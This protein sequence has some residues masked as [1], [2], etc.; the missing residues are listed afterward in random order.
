MAFLFWQIQ[1][2]SSPHLS[3]PTRPSKLPR[4]LQR[5]VPFWNASSNSYAAPE[6][7]REAIFHLHRCFNLLND[8]MCNIGY[9]LRKKAGPPTVHAITL[10]SIKSVI[11]TDEMLQIQLHFENK[12][13]YFL[14]STPRLAEIWLCG[15]CCLIRGQQESHPVTNASACAISIMLTMT[16]GKVSRYLHESTLASLSYWVQ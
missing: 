6:F 8:D 4:L 15:L 2:S 12:P 11:H 10:S 7:A 14:F 13:H 1:K 5:S 16:H 3:E 9:K